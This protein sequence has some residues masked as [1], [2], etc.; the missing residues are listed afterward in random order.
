MRSIPSDFRRALNESGLAAFFM[1]S[2]SVHQAGY[3]SWINETRRPETR[4]AKIRKAILRLL[5]QRAED[6]AV[7]V[8]RR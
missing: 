6:A 1:E 7:R 3:L 2:V 4:R 8:P 5:A